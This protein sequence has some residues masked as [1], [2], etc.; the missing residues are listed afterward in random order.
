MEVKWAY[1]G[2]LIFAGGSLAGDAEGLF[3][4]IGAAFTGAGFV[5]LGLCSFK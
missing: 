2:T 3:S 4:M 5:W 1:E